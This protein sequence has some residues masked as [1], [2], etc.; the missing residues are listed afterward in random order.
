LSVDMEIGAIPFRRF[1]G[2]EFSPSNNSTYCPAFIVR[3]TKSRRLFVWAGERRR[4][5]SELQ[6]ASPSVA[7]CNGLAQPTRIG[8]PR[9]PDHLL[10]AEPLCTVGTWS[11]RSVSHFPP[12]ASV[13]NGNGKRLI[14]ARCSLQ[15]CLTL[16]N[17]LTYQFYLDWPYVPGEELF[18]GIDS[19]RIGRCYSSRKLGGAAHA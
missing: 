4:R 9:I 2:N 13:G 11:C 7:T 18:E 19:A 12:I 6:F 14:L 16:S 17:F 8:A 10:W 15:F 3:M 5:T 1:D